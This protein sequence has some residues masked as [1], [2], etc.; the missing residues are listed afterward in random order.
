MRTHLNQVRESTN[1]RCYIKRNKLHVNDNAP[2]R[3]TISAP[4]TPNNCPNR[5]VKIEKDAQQ[6]IIWKPRIN[7]GEKHTK[8]GSREETKSSRDL[9]ELHNI[10][11]TGPINKTTQ[12]TAVPL[13]KEAV[14]SR[15]RSNK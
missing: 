10:P 15:L 14:K 5:S 13:A 11:K 7:A 6:H 3:K 8:S 12:Q 4:P 2:G 1:D 9:E